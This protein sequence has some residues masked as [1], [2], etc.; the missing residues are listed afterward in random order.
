MNHEQ[1]QLCLLSR[2]LENTCQFEIP[3]FSSPL[4][5]CPIGG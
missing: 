2:K 4:K 3:K 1:D 5:F